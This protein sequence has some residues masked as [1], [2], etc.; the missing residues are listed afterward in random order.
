MSFNL[1]EISH[2]LLADTFM[3]FQK[4]DGP[5]GYPTQTARQNICLYPADLI[6][7]PHLQMKAA[8]ECCQSSRMN[9]SSLQLEIGQQDVLEVSLKTSQFIQMFRCIRVLFSNKKVVENPAFI[10]V[11]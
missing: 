2:P 3:A 11:Y 10:K 4:R 6:Y 1:E 7:L 5:K 8:S 9:N